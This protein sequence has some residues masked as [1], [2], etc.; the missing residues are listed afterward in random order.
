MPSNPNQI[1]RND[2]R[3]IFFATTILTFT[4][5]GENDSHQRAYQERLKG[6]QMLD[7][8]D[9][10]SP[11]LRRRRLKNY[12]RP[13]L[14]CLVCLESAIRKELDPQEAYSQVPDRGPQIR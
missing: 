1:P 8:L 14:A 3:T 12:F 13:S 2:R 4:E 5:G 11:E 10:D 6:G 7:E 9:S